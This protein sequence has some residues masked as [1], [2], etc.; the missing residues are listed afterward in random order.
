MYPQGHIVQHREY[1]QYFITYF[2]PLALHFGHH[3]VVKIYSHISDDQIVFVHY[4]SCLS[5]LS[6]DGYLVSLYISL[7][8]DTML[9][10]CLMLLLHTMFCC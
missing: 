8:L 9:C 5:Q 4:N 10:E 3:S 2:F 7:V 6:A 1:D